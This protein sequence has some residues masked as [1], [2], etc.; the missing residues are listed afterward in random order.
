MRH[1][2]PFAGMIPRKGQQSSPAGAL[3]E[4]GVSLFNLRSWVLV[5]FTFPCLDFFTVFS[6]LKGPVWS[7]VFLVDICILH[8]NISFGE[9]S[10]HCLVN[11]VWSVL[12][13]VSGPQHVCDPYLLNDEALHTN[14][15]GCRKSPC[16]D[17]GGRERA[18]NRERRRGREGSVTGA[19]MSH[20]VNAEGRVLNSH[21][22]MY[23]GTNMPG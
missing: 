14:W 12:R 1:S 22:E 9:Q 21:V 17:R 19:S 18:R 4:R 20:C 2:R 3:R 8:W 13:T 16:Q 15:G 10:P 23:W 7:L 5:I 11:H 6:C